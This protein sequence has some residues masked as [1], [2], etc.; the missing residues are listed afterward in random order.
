M[1]QP[2]E[3]LLALADFNDARLDE[4]ERTAH[5]AVDPERQLR[6][7]AAKRLLISSWRRLINQIAVE[8]DPAKRECLALTRHGLDQF[9]HQMAAVHDAHPDYRQSWR[10]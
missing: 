2:T 1:S 9:A 4:D 5:T 6:E 10:P 8:E 7:I 3:H